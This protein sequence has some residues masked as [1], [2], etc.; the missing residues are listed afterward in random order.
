MH[1]GDEEL[2]AAGRS[3]RAERESPTRDMNL[4]FVP[5]ALPSLPVSPA[6]VSQNL[7]ASLATNR[8]ALGT[9]TR[10]NKDVVQQQ[11]SP[12]APRSTTMLQ[13]ERTNPSAR[14][15]QSAHCHTLQCISLHA[16]YAY[17]TINSTIILF[18]ISKWA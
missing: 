9:C 4:V 7:W 16:L 18:H 13:P 11:S 2:G 6:K 8:P 15:Q 12:Q 14:T 3:P 1:R 10:S 5:F 17:I